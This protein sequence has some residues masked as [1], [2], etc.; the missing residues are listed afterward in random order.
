MLVV[1]VLASIFFLG[2]REA[3]P[4]TLS[5][6]PDNLKG[7]AIAG[8]HVVFLVTA[9]NEGSSQ[10]EAVVKISA[11]AP[12]STVSI[13]PDTI[14]SGEVGEVTIIPDV[15]SVGNNITVTVNAER[16]GLKESQT[17]NFAVVEGEDDRADYA[18]QIRDKFVQWLE[19]SHPELGIKNGTEWVGTMV[20][21]IWLVVSH[22]LF[23]SN[24]WEMHVYW[25]IMIP[26]YDWARIDLRHRF[27]EVT[28]SLA[29]E[30]SSLSAN[31]S[32]IVITPPE[33]VWR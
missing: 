16:S 19:V 26:P 8:Q 27:T 28:P 17:V 13:E 9:T 21:P 10:D 3:T 6:V 23:F 33:S 1:L 12:G 15:A 5:V 31:L 18:T 7:D 20:S 29:F 14:S 11:T 25:H 24:D 32:P 22:Y 2:G 30:I 4:Y